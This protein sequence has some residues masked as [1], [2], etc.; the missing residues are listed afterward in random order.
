MVTYKN[1]PLSH[2]LRLTYKCHT[3]M[4][5]P[6]LYIYIYRRTHDIYMCMGGLCIYGDHGEPSNERDMT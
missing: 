2:Y 3:D 5:V 1:H 4:C 6:H